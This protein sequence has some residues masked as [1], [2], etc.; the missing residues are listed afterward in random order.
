LIAKFNDQ[1]PLDV[2][3]G[4]A[5]ISDHSGPNKS[6]DGLY[7][8]TLQVNVIACHILLKR[9]LTAAVPPKRICVTSSG[10][11]KMPKDKIDLTNLNFEKEEWAWPKAYSRSKLLEIM[12][13]VGAFHKGLIP[14]TTT[15]LCFCPGFIA[16]AIGS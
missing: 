14:A 15:V 3:I 2:F 12:L 4:N 11:H 10:A 16:T 9:L 7:D 13:C 5:S 8:L 1:C 6:A